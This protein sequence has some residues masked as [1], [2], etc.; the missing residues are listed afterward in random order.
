[1]KNIILIGISVFLFFGIIKAQKIIPVI[2]AGHSEEIMFAEWDPESRY[3]ATADANNE[4]VIYDFISGRMFYKIK[5]PVNDFIK[6]IS[7]SNPER[8]IVAFE[9]QSYEFNLKT[10]E[11]HKVSQ[12]IKRKK[13][14]DRLKIHGSLIKYNG[15]SLINRD[16]YTHFT[17]AAISKDEKFVIAGDERGYIYFCN[18]RLNT[19]KVEHKHYL[20]INDIVFSDNNK[21]V[22]IASS[23]RSVSVWSLPDLKFEK[24]LIP[25][26]FNVTAI[27]THPKESV[28][29]FGDELGFVYLMEFENDKITCNG[30]SVHNGRI[31][32]VDMGNNYKI[33]AT[34]GGDNRA[35]VADLENKYVLKSFI[36]HPKT[37]RIKETFNIKSI[38][39]KVTSN[40]EN[41]TWY[42]KNVYSVTLNPDNTNIAYS[43]GKW[44]IGNPILKVSSV[45]DLNLDKEK[46][47]RRPKKENLGLMSK[48]NTHKFYQLYFSNSKEFY[49]FGEKP[50]YATN[51]NLNLTG[52]NENKDIKIEN[53]NFRENPNLLVIS[54]KS[55]VSDENEYLVKTNPFTK[56]K[57]ICKGFVIERKT[58]NKTIE[59][60]GHKSYITDFEIL[61]QKNFLISSSM[62]A[63]VNIWDLNS[64]ELLLTVYVVDIGKLIFVT[65]ANYY[66]AAGEAITG[67]GFNFDAK[68]FPADQF[69]LKFN[70]PDLVLK[71]LKYFDPDIV[72][73]Y[74]SAYNKRLSKLGF[75]AKMLEGQMNLPKIEILNSQEIK[76]RNNEG[77]QNLKVK[78]WDD[79]YIIDRINVYVNDVPL[80]GSKGLSLKEKS[81]KNLIQE[82]QIPLSAG[83]NLIQLSCLNEKGVESL[84]EE[85]EIFFEKTSK[86][87]PDLYLI[88]FA[89]ADYKQSQYSLKYTINDGRGFVKLFSSKTRD[90]NKIYV[91]TLYNMNC[92]KE[93]VLALKQKLMQTKVDDYVVI[94][95]AGH[96]LLDDNLDFYFASYDIDFNDP[97]K[98]GIKYDDIEGLLDG[99]PARNKLLLMDACHSGEVDKDDDLA[100]D[101]K[102][103]DNTRGVTLFA[104]KSNNKPKTGLKNSYE[105]M[106]IL[107]AD[108]QKGTGAVVISAASGTGYALE[109]ENIQNGIFTHC[110]LKGIKENKADADKNKVVTVSE[111]RN[112]IFDGVKELSNG[113]QQPTSRKENLLNDFV[114]WRY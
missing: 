60:I 29:C 26:S 72:D 67:L 36:L 103:G 61:T 49:G 38:Q 45:S 32:D 95:I 96:G 43:G 93:N 68:V 89:V 5:I 30:I 42:D 14:D 11:L 6:S 51:F 97:A 47:K 44:G 100:L 46:D 8:I 10:L 66:M 50:D 69:D 70:R 55:E 99:I 78:I 7:F 104:Q 4:L 64:G 23:D 92:T 34:A 24:R 108:L 105:L 27:Q 111:L 102:D 57:Y 39:D 41:K 86:E 13:L 98:R 80:Y 1:M 113:K 112:Y 31:N 54:S 19:I 114:I 25:R 94:H 37:T 82:V 106:K 16:V 74:H 84:K 21:Y 2:Q 12:Q 83:K 109:N 79:N 87:K 17:F 58:E 28:V 65:P 77:Q 81:S 88:S 33:I 15:K 101:S 63:S 22:A 110:L 73:L 90:Y 52:Y 85:L 75:T 18:S 107:F 91:D 71:Q 76:F 40:A 53:I 48:N 59:Y 35:A 9:N 56:D 20:G 3:I 62:D